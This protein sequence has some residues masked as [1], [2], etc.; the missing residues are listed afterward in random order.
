MNNSE[1]RIVFMGTP[2]F[3]VSVLEGLIN[4][5][6]NLVAVVTQPDKPVGRDG[7]VKISPVKECALKYDIPIFQPIR[8]R[9]EYEK[10]LEYKPDIIITCA[11]GQIIPKEII[12][13]PKYKCINV[14]A[15]LLP[16]YRGGAPI[17]HSIINGDKKTGITIMH[18]DYGMDNGDILFQKEIEI[19]DID[20][21]ETLFDKLKILGRDLLIEKMPYIIK[22][23]IEPIKQNEDEVT[24]AYNIKP[25]D[26]VVD[27]NKK[28][29]EIYNQ[30]RGLNSWPVAYTM[31][32]N[33]R[34]KIWES[35]ISNINIEGTPGEIVSLTNDGI[36]IKTIDGVIL[37]TL[38][39]PEGKKKM[40]AK[41][42]I[43]GIR[44]EEFI[45]KIMK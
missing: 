27:F 14:H 15:S 29:I 1:V 2:D 18:M 37:L 7:K 40:N 19:S 31:L 13:Y 32:D 44:K 39:Q 38:I 17:H 43:N 16:K 11:Y 28:T 42:F 12:D 30:I 34:I 10:V 41:D 36:G 26:E 24:Y 21:A 45:G 35:K 33:K 23:E 4:S 22:G 25:E 3:S 5:N 6:Y 8:I 20:T 9:K